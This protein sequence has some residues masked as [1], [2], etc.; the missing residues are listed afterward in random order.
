MSHVT[1]WRILRKR[2]ACKPYRLQ[3]LQALTPKDHN[4]RHDFCW[5]FQER[6]QEGADKLVFSDEECFHL[7]GK[8]NLHNVRIW[9]TEDLVQ[10]FNIFV[11][12]PSLMCFVQFH[13]G[14]CT[15]HF[16]LPR[17]VLMVL[18]T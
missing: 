9:G 17:K 3:L 5:E 12:L 8:V 2:L 4:L 10:Q 6:I 11:I 7:S 18:L 14:K 1:V 16:S 15:D 13:L